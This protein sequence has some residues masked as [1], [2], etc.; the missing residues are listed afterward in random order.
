[1][2]QIWKELSEKIK[3]VGGN[4]TAFTAVGGFT[5]YVLGYLVLRFHLTCLGVGTD[6]AVLDERYL[7]AGTKFLVYF[8]SSIPIS[9]F[10]LLVVAAPLYVPYRMLPAKIRTIVKKRFDGII[11]G[12][13]SLLS[14]PKRL[15]FMGILWSVCIIQFVMRQSFLFSNLLV[16]PCLPEPPWLRT[17]VT[18]ES[19]GLMSIYFAGL[20]MACVVSS[21][22]LV[23]ISKHDQGN[24]VSPFI[25]GLLMILVAVQWFLLPINY[26]ILVYDKSFPRVGN[27]QGKSLLPDQK[28]WL[29]WEGKDGITYLSRTVESGKAQRTLITIPKSEVKE[30]RISTYDK[31]FPTLFADQFD[32]S[33]RE[34]PTK[35]AK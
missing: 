5:L 32:C 10:L 4:W 34:N 20:I 13:I 2:S 31:I 24:S 1:M 6:L 19:D 35:E 12:L 28:V 33:D 22:C 15:A 11:E 26:G 7:F 14:S 9:V 18:A 21:G 27:L 30:T 23:S 16:S 29:V 25:K 8:V 17:L 3:D